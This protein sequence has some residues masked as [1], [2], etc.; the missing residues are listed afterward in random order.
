M[1]P[2]L[3]QKPKMEVKIK[4]KPLNSNV[5]SHKNFSNTNLKIKM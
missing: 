5:Q 4:V 2:K 1:R 3:K